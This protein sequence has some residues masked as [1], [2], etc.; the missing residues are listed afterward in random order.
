MDWLVR[1][2]F[3]KVDELKRAATPWY[4][5]QERKN[6]CH[7]TA[8]IEVMYHFF[9][10]A[11]HYPRKGIHQFHME[12]DSYM[13]DALDLSCRRIGSDL[14]RT[15]AM[16][17][18][19][20]GLFLDNNPS[21][22][23]QYTAGLQWMRALSDKAISQTRQERLEHLEGERAIAAVIRASTMATEME[24]TY[25]DEPL[26]SPA[27]SVLNGT[28]EWDSDSNDS[29]ETASHGSGQGRPGD[30]PHRDLSEFDSDNEGK[31]TI[32]PTIP[33]Y[34]P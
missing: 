31:N 20:L 18:K 26:S 28:G 16:R 30:S 3:T 14:Y 32:F 8:T 34:A 11:L 10:F 13:E 4:S 1:Y 27:S 19:A 5:A 6:Q 29:W 17:T 23:F 2:R 24:E 9:C 22:L 7:D 33:Y 15:A 12:E 21:F 25:M